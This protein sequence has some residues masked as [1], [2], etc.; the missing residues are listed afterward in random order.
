MHSLLVSFHCKNRVLLACCKQQINYSECTLQCQEPA[1]ETFGER[2]NTVFHTL[3][4][5]YEITLDGR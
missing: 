1:L 2:P 3:E 4:H 5:N